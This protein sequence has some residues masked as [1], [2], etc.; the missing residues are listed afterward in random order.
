MNYLSPPGVAVIDAVTNQMVSFV[1][2]EPQ[3]ADGGPSEFARSQVRITPNA[4]FAFAT[5]ESASSIHI[6]DTATNR[7]VGTASVPISPDV[8]NLDVA[9][10]PD[11]THAYVVSGPALGILVINIATRRVE[12][13]IP[14]PVDPDS[15]ELLTNS[16]LAI[17]PDGKTIYVATPSL[18]RVFVLDLGSRTVTDTLLVTDPDGPDYFA[19]GT[20]T[21]FT[22]R[23]DGGALFIAYGGET[24]LG[25][26]NPHPGGFYVMDLVTKTAGHVDI[27]GFFGH[28]PSD[29]VVSLDGRT[30]YVV[31]DDVFVLDT[32]VPAIR[33]TISITDIA[34]D[35]ARGAALTPD[36]SR[37]YVTV[38]ESGD[39][40]AL[41]I[42]TNARQIIGTLKP[43][44]VGPSG[45][46]I[47]APP[48]GLCV[49]DD[50]GQ[51][52]VTVGELVTSVNY[53]ADGCPSAMMTVAPQS[54]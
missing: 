43:F 26:S 15:F 7:S 10:S 4:A 51:T 44:G 28:G 39:T 24:S 14:L 48:T 34:S 42:D 32:T 29:A 53:A 20:P 33:T 37:L 23:P 46:A 16:R 3:F 40:A 30:A 11:A 8:E 50:Q 9:F 1:T 22:V 36:G 35:S 19:L 17:S 21:A 45:I 47:T 18:A 38:S 25:V 12:A 31:A 2:L 13:R 6:I 5:F 54:H 49:P 52:R 27:K 41:V